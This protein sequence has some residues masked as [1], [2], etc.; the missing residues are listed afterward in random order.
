M[1]C[2]YQIFADLERACKPDAILSSN[3]STIDL[4]LIG[5][6]TS[7]PDRIVGAHF[8]S[9]AHVMP[10]LE[11]VRTDKTSPQVCSAICCKG[12]VCFVCFF[13]FTEPPLWFMHAVGSCTFYYF[14][15]HEQI[16]HTVG[17]TVVVI[18]CAHLPMHTP[19]WCS[20][21]SILESGLKRRLLWLATAPGLRSI[22]CFFRIRKQRACWW[23]WEE[24]HMP[25]TRQSPHLACP[26]DPS[27][28]HQPRMG[29]A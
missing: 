26:W 22:V 24:S 23:T 7:C 28:M 29:S 13:P 27:G 17:G 6:K 15:F 10:L 1:A 4:T 12:F 2:T 8:F 5:A 25:S 16:T 20:T 9:P 11:I 21:R 19:R 18:D 3:T 14:F